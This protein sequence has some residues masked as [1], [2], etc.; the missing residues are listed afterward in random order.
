MGSISRRGFLKGAGLI[1]AMGAVGATGAATLGLAGCSNETA[2][3]AEA[4]PRPYSV[5]ESDVVVIGSGISGLYAAWGALQN[6]A[7]V[8]ILDKGRYGRS[9]NSGMNWGNM[10]GALEIVGDK[11]TFM[12]MRTSDF[13]GHD[14]LCD[15]DLAVKIEEA[16]WEC[17]PVVAA[18]QLGCILERTQDGMPAQLS[19]AAAGLMP[20]V[21]AQKVK[22]LGANI[23]DRTF[24]QSLLLT[25]DKQHIAG[26]VAIDLKDGTAHVH[27]A[28]SVVMAAGSYIWAS[29]WSGLRPHTHGSA[30]LTGEGLAMLL[31]AGIP[32][33]NCEIQEHDLSQYT[34]MAIRNTVAAMGIQCTSWAWAYNNDGELFYEAAAAAGGVGQGPFM[35]ATLRELHEGRGTEHGG[36][37]A[38]T[39]DMS[40][41]ER[42]WRRSKEDE[43]R[44]LGYEMKDREE[45]VPHFWACGM[46]PY[47]LSDN[48][49]TVI[50]GL[51]YA[52]E[53]PYIFSGGSTN[54][55]VGTG[56]LSGTGAGKAKDQDMPVVNWADVD[57]ALNAA[58]APLER[59]S[60]SGLRPLDVMRSIQNAFWDGLGLIRDGAGIQAAIDELERIKAE[61]L[62]KMACPDKSPVMN[63]DWRMSMEI[64]G[65]LDDCLACGYASQK[66]TCSRGVSF[67]RS[68]YPE[69]GDEL[70]NTVT[71]YVDGQ[72]SVETKPIRDSKQSA[73]DILANELRISFAHGLE[74]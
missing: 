43:Y 66:R 73:E 56:W 15:Q 69:M 23:V 33:T 30:D 55:C 12:A 39:T 20:R 22:R 4:T 40:R 44:T 38:D 52:G 31:Q 49:E 19:N 26:V 72:W 59:A 18:E 71:T 48:C 28:K 37:W 10:W 46:M 45:L 62:P 61:D 54:A 36:L 68:D 64:P 74:A 2:S 8:T 29:G 3:E 70:Y 32:M 11:D 51:Y 21:F 47:D 24:A 34:P 27:R 42:F 35:R 17:K 67:V 1:G 9:G 63:P 7:T 58:Y 57:A 65:M 13:T 14:G 5:H 6:G 41:V 50:G 60:E 53:A 16:Y 25:E